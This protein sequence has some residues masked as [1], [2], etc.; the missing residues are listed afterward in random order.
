MVT[1]ATLTG[2]GG[3]GGVKVIGKATAPEDT[4]EPSALVIVTV[5]VAASEVWS[6]EGTATPVWSELGESNTMLVGSED[7][8][9]TDAPEGRVVMGLPE[10]SNKLA[11]RVPDEPGAKP[12]NVV[13]EGVLE[14]LPMLVA[15]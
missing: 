14:V 5:T 7:S 9:A 13:C 4:V 10:A 15:P 11:V 2:G 8:Q 6:V 3:G 12:A 1:L